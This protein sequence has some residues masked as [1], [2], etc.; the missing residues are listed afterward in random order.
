V[1]VDNIEREQDLEIELKITK[2]AI[3]TVA[4]TNTPTPR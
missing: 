1:V 2:N 4:Q 3:V